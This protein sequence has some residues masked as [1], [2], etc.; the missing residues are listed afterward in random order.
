MRTREIAASH[1]PSEIVWENGG[2]EAA[3]THKRYNA[4]ESHNCPR[5]EG[6]GKICVFQSAS[7]ESE[8]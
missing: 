8:S 7:L 3:K 1:L 5:L 6:Y 2:W 4:V